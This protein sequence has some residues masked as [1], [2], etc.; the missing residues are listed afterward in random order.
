MGDDSTNPDDHFVA[1][2]GWE[3]ITL[4]PGLRSE[5]GCRA[6]TASFTTGSSDFTT[7][8][9]DNQVPFIRVARFYIF[10][11]KNSNLGKFWRVLQWKMLVYLM[12]I[13]SILRSF[14]MAIWYI[15]WLLGIFFPFWY[16]VQR[17]IWQPCTPSVFN[18]RDLLIERRYH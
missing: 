15:L 4:A 5:T 1:R 3:F 17:K 10:K 6:R 18:L 8:G 12:V 13:W 9:L 7:E 14:G 11:P 2:N 16:V